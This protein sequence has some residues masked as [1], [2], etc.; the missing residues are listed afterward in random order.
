MMGASRQV[1]G[2]VDQSGHRQRAHV[3]IVI[4]WLKDSMQGNDESAMPLTS[5]PAS[6]KLPSAAGSTEAHSYK[7]SENT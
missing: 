4:Q 2:L 3:S 1:A 7:Q 6:S 5:E